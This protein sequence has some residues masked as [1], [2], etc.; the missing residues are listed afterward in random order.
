MSR[1]VSFRQALDGMRS[2]A[3]RG[4]SRAITDA[5]RMAPP[6]SRNS[7]GGAAHALFDGILEALSET[8]V[9]VATPGYEPE[10]AAL[11]AQALVARVYQKRAERL[12]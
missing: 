11:V 12:Q 9:D 1:G 7:P 3:H 6:P 8:I 10:L 4:V 2:Q 5:R